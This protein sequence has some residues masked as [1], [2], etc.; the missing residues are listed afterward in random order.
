MLHCKVSGFQKLLLEV[1]S[2]LEPLAPA[3]IAHLNESSLECFF[4][5]KDKDI[6]DGATTVSHT[7]GPRRGAGWAQ[8]DWIR[9]ALLT[10]GAP[11]TCPEPDNASLSCRI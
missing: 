5:A 9:P 8:L 4:K 7:Q 3:T 10:A 6:I 1:T 2:G 11:L